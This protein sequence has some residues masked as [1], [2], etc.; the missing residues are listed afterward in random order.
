M[1]S[2]DGRIFCSFFATRHVCIVIYAE[3]DINI[4]GYGTFRHLKELEI[5]DFD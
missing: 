4:D 2:I 5:C 1:I 3:I